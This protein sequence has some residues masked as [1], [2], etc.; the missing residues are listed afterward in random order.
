MSYCL[1]GPLPA[2]AVMQS[3]PAF[4]IALGMLLGCFLRDIGWVRSIGRTWAF[5]VKVT[6]WDKVQKLAEDEQVKA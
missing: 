2:F 3:W 5:S 1:G 6:D 4:W